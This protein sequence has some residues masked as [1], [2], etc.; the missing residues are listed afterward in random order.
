M[1]REGYE[2]VELFDKIDERFI[3]E[4][5]GEWEKESRASL[6]HSKGF[7]AA[8]AVLCISLIGVCLFQPQVQAAIQKFAGRIA[9]VWGIEKDLSPYT[10]VIN[11][12]QKKEGLSLTLNEVIFSGGRIYAVVTMDSEY[13]YADTMPD[14]YVTINGKDYYLEGSSVQSE[15]KKRQYGHELGHEEQ[16]APYLFIMSLRENIPETVTDMELH[17]K[18]YKNWEDMLHRV[19][20]VTF[21]FAFRVSKDELE[22]KVV[23]IPMD[24]AFMLENGK[25]MILTGLTITALDSEIKAEMKNIPETE[26]EEWV[27]G[28]YYLEGEDSLGNDVGYYWAGGEFDAG[29]RNGNVTFISELPSGMLPSVDAEWMDLQL[30][31]YQRMERVDLGEKFRVYLK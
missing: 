27:Y 8:C 10:E 15:Q 26:M 29:G 17:F 6:F 14:E 30:Y 18:A 9:Q 21:D 13:E 31:T 11:Q 12:E 3:G 28:E 1:K 24:E 23:H 7:R 2:F 19:D 4:A 22:N 20:Y 16:N 25:E 5:D